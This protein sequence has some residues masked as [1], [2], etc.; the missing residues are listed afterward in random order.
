MFQARSPAP[1]TAMHVRACPCDR[2]AWACVVPTD[3]VEILLSRLAGATVRVLA[4]HREGRH[5]ML[6]DGATGRLARL[7]GFKHA[8]GRCSFTNPKIVFLLTR[9]EALGT[10]AA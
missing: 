10:E 6:L 4:D 5:G 3:Q 1:S 7:C 8:N 2:C 9:P